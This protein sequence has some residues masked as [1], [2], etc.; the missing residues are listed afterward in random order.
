[1][2]WPSVHVL[3]LRI[4]CKNEEEEKSRTLEAS[5]TSRASFAGIEADITTR[6][7]GSTAQQ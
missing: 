2:K 5:F 3:A 4:A 7:L 1:M 6:I